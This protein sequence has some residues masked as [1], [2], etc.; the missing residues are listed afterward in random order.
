MLPIFKQQC[1]NIEVFIIEKNSTDLDRALASG[2]IDFAIMH[3]LPFQEH[4]NKL[5]NNTYSLFKDPMLLVT[6]KD[7]PLGAYAVN[8]GKLK[9]PKIDIK[10]FA[11]EPFVMLEKGQKIRQVTELVLQKVGINPLTVLTTKSFETARRLAAE[12]IGI[13]MVPEQYL[14]IFPGDYKPDYYYMDEDLSAYWTMCV[15]VQK[16]AYISTA[17]KLFINMVNE[18]MVGAKIFK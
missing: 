6:K 5:T 1:P 14:E 18:K 15:A 7:H 16:D 17:A 12:G 3:T 11:Q 9:Y 2:E 13:T 4:I 10:K 8:D